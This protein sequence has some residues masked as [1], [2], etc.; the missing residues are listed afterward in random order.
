MV[1]EAGSLRS[2]C[3]H[4]Q[5]MVNFYEAA[6]WLAD[7]SLLAM[8]SQGE[9]RGSELSGISYKEIL[10]DQSPIYTL[11]LPHDVI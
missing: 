3:Q 10:V 4:S 8:S 11:P 7:G 1:L 6:S 9:E 2:E 5:I